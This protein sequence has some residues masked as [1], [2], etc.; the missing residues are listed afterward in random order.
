METGEVR[1]WVNSLGEDWL[2]A[3]WLSSTVCVVTVRVEGCRC[4][5]GLQG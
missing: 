4:I 2:D 1:E 3:A 5:V